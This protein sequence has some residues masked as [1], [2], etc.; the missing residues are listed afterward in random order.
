[1]SRPSARDLAEARALLSAVTDWIAARQDS[2][3]DVS[4]SVHPAT[5]CRVGGHLVAVCR[6]GSRI[7][8]VATAECSCPDNGVCEHLL[9]AL[10][11]ELP[12]VSSGR[13]TP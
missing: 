3:L 13:R 9:V 4:V 6:F 12:P 10:A 8:V 1:V 11:Y 7:G 2:S 5:V